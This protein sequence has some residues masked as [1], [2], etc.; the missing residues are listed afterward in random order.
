M[1]TLLK[2]A[3]ERSNKHRID[4][5]HGCGDSLLLLLSHPDI[6][7]PDLVHGITSLPEHHR[8]SQARVDQLL[9]SEPR[10]VARPQVELFAG[11]AVWRLEERHPLSTES[12]QL[13]D[14]VLALDCA[15]HFNTRRKFLSQ[16]FSHLRPGGRIALA[17]ICFKSPPSGVVTWLLSKIL[18][19]M[20]RANVQSKLD[21]V[22]EM[23]AL[24][25]ADVTME[26]I[27]ED[28]FPG[29]VRF[30]ATQSL[31]FRLFGKSIILLQALGAR[32]VIVT[33]TRT[34]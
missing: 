33:G 32:F 10:S 29:F 22:A 16:S 28:V 7:R 24:G 34:T 31:A 30:L 2:Y 18:R 15:Y 5:G 9:S 23:E 6:P 27:T 11:D 3:T 8:R 1:C 4:V 17:D 25:Y 21:Y 19:A 12:S 26:D 13:F 20:P 14:I